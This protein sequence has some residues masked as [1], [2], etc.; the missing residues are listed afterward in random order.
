[1]PARVV[2]ENCEPNQV[3]GVHLGHALQVIGHQGTSEAS[4][5][6][7]DSPSAFFD[8]VYDEMLEGRPYGKA[9][10][11]CYAAAVKLFAIPRGSY[12]LTLRVEGDGLQSRKQ[13]G[14][15]QDPRTQLL[16]MREV[17]Q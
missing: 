5:Q 14:I 13:F 10:G 16:T 17:S 12:V 2:L 8:V 6:P 11:L 4:V 9:F 3:D 7:G 15:Y 1:V